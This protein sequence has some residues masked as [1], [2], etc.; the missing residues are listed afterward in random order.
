MIRQFGP[1]KYPPR[2][3]HFRVEDSPPLDNH[4]VQPKIE[5]LYQPTHEEL[6]LASSDLEDC[7][8]VWIG[9]LSEYIMETHKRQ[10]QVEIWFEASV[11]VS[12]GFNCHFNSCMK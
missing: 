7:E 3:K 12:L 11:L 6:R 2:T 4:D 1:R 5:E 9:E 8:E 10:K